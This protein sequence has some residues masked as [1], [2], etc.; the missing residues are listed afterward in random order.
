MPGGFPGHYLGDRCIGARIGVGARTPFRCR[1]KQRYGPDCATTKTLNGRLSAHA[2]DN[3]R[4]SHIMPQHK[5]RYAPE[6][7]TRN[8]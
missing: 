3:R 1:E 2:G 5:P 4:N 6:E 7:F 8:N